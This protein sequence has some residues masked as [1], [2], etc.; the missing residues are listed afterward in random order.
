MPSLIEDRQGL[1]VE[2]LCMTIHKETVEDNANNGWESH[3]EIMMG[4]GDQMKIQMLEGGILCC[5]PSG[6]YISRSNAT[7]R[8]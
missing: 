4:V 6:L 8:C 5:L 7:W 3:D 2:N 1:P